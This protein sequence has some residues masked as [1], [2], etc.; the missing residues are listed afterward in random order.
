MEGRA[1]E[2][3]NDP[4][5]ARASPALARPS[6]TDLRSTD[7]GSVTVD[8][9]EFWRIVEAGRLA[10]GGDDE[11]VPSAVRGLLA[12]LP[13]SEIISFETI[14]DELLGESYRNDLWAAAYLINGGCSDD[15]FTYFRG[16]LIAQ[17]QRVFDTAI[18]DPAT[19]EDA[20][21]MDN[22]WDADLEE[23]LYAARQAYRDVVGAEMPERS[24][25]AWELTGPEWDEDSVF[26][27][28]PALNAKAES[29][30]KR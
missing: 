21:V 17:G 19:L 16:W 6:Q 2:Q 18:L 27:M 3:E 29:R 15:G 23:F 26:D 30:F 22:A 20:I 4:D 1:A 28:Y 7:T 24:L 10:A 13:P 12:A 25:P 14:Q 8:R 11:R 9:A 5:E